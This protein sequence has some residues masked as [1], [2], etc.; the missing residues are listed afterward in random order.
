MMSN[1][2][3]WEMLD[4]EHPSYVTHLVA[5]INLSHNYDGATPLHAFLDMVGFSEHEYGISLCGEMPT[6]DYMSLD[7]LANALQE[8]VV[9]PHDVLDWYRQLQAKDN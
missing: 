7:Y 9:R 1:A 8:Y 3:Y 2:T 5:L 6:L 4:T